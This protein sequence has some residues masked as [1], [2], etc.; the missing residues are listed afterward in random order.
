[1]AGFARWVQEQALPAVEALACPQGPFLAGA[2]PSVADICLVPQLYNARRF[3]VDLRPFP[4]LE[5]AEQ[6][7]FAQYP[8]LISACPEAQP[9]CPPP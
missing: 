4:R 8:Q 7:L 2:E 5:R 6:T 1:M 9:D 3:N